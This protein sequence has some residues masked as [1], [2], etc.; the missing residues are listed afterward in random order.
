MRQSLIFNCCIYWALMIKL[1]SKSSLLLDIFASS[2][3]SGPLIR[4]LFF[5]AKIVCDLAEPFTL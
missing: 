3:S 4:M 1:N 5:L 2:F